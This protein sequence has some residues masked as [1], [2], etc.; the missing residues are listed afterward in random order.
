MKTKT[1][2]DILIDVL[3]ATRYNLNGSVT[4]EQLIYALEKF[5][6]Q[7]QDDNGR[8]NYYEDK[9]ESLTRQYRET[10]KEL[11]E[12]KN[13]FSQ[14]PAS[15]T[16]EQISEIIEKAVH[17]ARNEWTSHDE[18]ENGKGALIKELRSLLNHPPVM[19]EGEKCDCVIPKPKDPYDKLDKNI[20]RDCNRTIAHQANT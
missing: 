19:G 4:N 3:G 5:G 8:A 14:L 15:V 1:A 12:Y 2:E 11:Q 18:E 16:D 9:I 10:E 7:F 20:C 6:C 17:G 13:Q